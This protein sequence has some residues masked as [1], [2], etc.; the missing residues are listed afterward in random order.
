MFLRIVFA[1]TRE[2]LV[3]ATELLVLLDVLYFEVVAFVLDE[4]TELLRLKL[5]EDVLLKVLPE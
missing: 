3:L 4:F 1:S 2:V 5:F